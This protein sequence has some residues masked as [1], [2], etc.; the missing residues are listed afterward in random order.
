MKEG[1]IRYECDPASHYWE[2]ADRASANIVPIVKKSRG[3]GEKR[4]KGLVRIYGPGREL[5]KIN[6]VASMVADQLNDGLIK[7]D[8][9]YGKA[10]MSAVLASKK[11][12][13][14]IYE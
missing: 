3:K 11:L 14:N 4:A 9:F 7:E 2:T 6:K 8:V 1:V 10:S 13:L 12:R 5:K